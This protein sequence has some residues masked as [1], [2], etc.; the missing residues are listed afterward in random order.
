MRIHVYG[1]SWSAGLA[2]I[3]NFNCWPKALSKLEPSW[4]IYNF[5]C[6]GSSSHLATY[7][8][9]WTKKNITEPVFHIFQ[10]TSQYRWTYIDPSIDPM[11]YLEKIKNNYW[12]FFPKY[13][14]SIRDVTQTYQIKKQEKPPKHLSKHYKNKI[15]YEQDTQW[16][17]ERMCHFESLRNNIGLAFFHRK[18]DQQKY[19]DF[20]NNK[21]MCMQD[22]LGDKLFYHYCADAGMHFGKKGIEWQANHI[23]NHIKGNK[24]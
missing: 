15:K 1:C 10:G 8:Y 16:E 12:S 14:D 23:R 9:A 18:Q 4:Q 3:D 7:I 19:N 13:P 2:E 6:P 20:F 5:A 22:I 17:F 21:T 11:Y 24:Q